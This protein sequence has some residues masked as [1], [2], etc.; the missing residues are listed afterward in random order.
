[1]EQVGHTVM[2]LFSG[3][4]LKNSHTLEGLWERVSGLDA[5]PALTDPL[6]VAICYVVGH[7][8]LLQCSGMHL[9]LDAAT[10]THTHRTIY[11]TRKM[12]AAS[13]R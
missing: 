3:D 9:S 13:S 4:L 8:L 12:D 1:V 11:G 10:Y 5:F 6:L 7:S 2:L